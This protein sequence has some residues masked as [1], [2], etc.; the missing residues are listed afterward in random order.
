MIYQNQHFGIS[1]YFCKETGTDFCFPHHMHHSFE[2]ITVIEGKMTVTIADST[3]DLTQGEGALIF[4]EQIHSLESLEC[5]HMLVIFSPDI[6]SAYYTRHLLEI[7]CDNKINLPA[8]LE[9]QIGELD[10][11]SSIIKIKAALYSLCATLDEQTKYI[12][13][14]NTQDGLLRKMFDLVEENYDK[15]CNLSTVSNALGYNSSYL[16]RYFAETTKISFLSYVNRYRVSK[17]CYALRNTDKTAL[18][19]AYECGYGS[20]RSF[21]RNFKAIVG[22]TPREYRTKI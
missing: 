6:V 15:E 5:K 19:C 7:P 16:S 11:D 12:K 21:N 17:A 2:F 13:K 1:E 14:K 3:Y 9:D 8:H 18:E 4:P 10:Q 20:L 22:M